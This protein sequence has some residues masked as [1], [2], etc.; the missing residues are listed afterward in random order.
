MSDYYRLH[1]PIETERYIFRIAA[2]KAIM[3]AP[4]SYGYRLPDERIYRPIKFDMISVAIKRPISILGAAEAIGMDFKGLKDLNPQFIGE[5]LPAGSYS[6]K[7]PEGKGGRL[8]SYL[9][10]NKRVKFCKK[11]KGS[12]DYYVVKKG[13]TLFGI[14]E[15][16]GVSVSK[17]RRLN[18]IRGSMVVVGQ[19]LLIA[20]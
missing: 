18:K 7:A 17:L 1:L 13:D 14:S 20:P 11:D 10:D 16:T 9:K 19:R 2:A 6:L 5:C 12:R 4:Q 15:K 3:E 8:V